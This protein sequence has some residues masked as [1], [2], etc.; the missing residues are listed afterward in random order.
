MARTRIPEQD[1]SQDAPQTVAPV[2]LSGLTT[3]AAAGIGNAATA[4]AAGLGQ[5]G[6]QRPTD[7]SMY[8]PEYVRA[9]RENLGIPEGG[10][11]DFFNE[12]VG[13]KLAYQDLSSWANVKEGDENYETIQQQKRMLESWGYN[14]NVTAANEVVDPKT[15]LY[16]VRLDP[17]QQGMEQGRGSK[18]AFRGTEPWTPGQSGL[19]NPFGAINDVIADTGTSVGGNQYDANAGA[20]RNLMAGGVR[21]N[22]GVTGMTTT[23]HSLG[24]YLAQRAAAENGD[25]MKGGNVATFQAGGLNREVAN[26]F[27]ANQ[28]ENQI[29]VRHHYTQSDVVHRAGE[30]RLGGQFIEHNANNLVEGHTK[31]LMYSDS[32]MPLLADAAGGKTIRQSNEDSVSNWSRHLLEGGRTGLGGAIRTGMAPINA[33]WQTGVGLGNGIVNAAGGLATAATDTYNGVAGGMGTAWNG[34]AN[35]ASQMWNGDFFGGL[36]TMGGGLLSGTAQTIGGV[37]SG[38]LGVGKTAV[39]AVGDTAGA[40]WNGASSLVGDV[41]QGAYQMGRGGLNLVEGA[42]GG[43]IEAGKYVGGKAL[44]AGR[45][46]GNKAVEVGTAAVDATKAGAAWVGNKA[47]QAGTAVADGAAWAGGK[48]LDA[49]AAVGN[50][51]MD[52]AAWAGGK[53][54]DAGAAVGSG[55]KSAWDVATSW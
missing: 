28:G 9:N 6:F 15:G 18:V 29:G 45:Y 46:V 13:H 33:A 36:G 55:L 35:G 49:G 47:V 40:L 11:E 41:A 30:Q 38:L 17:N 31:G 5:G 39:G 44:D 50:A 51:A 4:A 42:V 7:I 37:G 16:A 19:T 24:G 34:A 12:F 32:A 21:G 48:V 26:R 25:L 23:G 10:E 14:S 3:G 52:G 43:T 8:T 22:G 2:S 54:M 27:E 53:V 1:V 20:I